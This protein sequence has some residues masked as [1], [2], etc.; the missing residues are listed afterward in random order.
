[1]DHLGDSLSFFWLSPTYAR[2]IYV[3]KFPLVFLPFICLLLM[4]SLSPE[5]R[6]IEGKLFFFP[7]PVMGR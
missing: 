7:A 3:I 2:G 1:M 5:P 6:I 4:G